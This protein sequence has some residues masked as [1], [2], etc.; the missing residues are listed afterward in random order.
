MIAYDRSHSS[1]PDVP[2]VAT[3]EALHAAA[4]RALTRPWF[5][6]RERTKCPQELSVACFWEAFYYYE[7]LRLYQS[8]VGGAAKRRQQIPLRTQRF[9][10]PAQPLTTDKLFL[11]HMPQSPS[12]F[13][14]LL[15]L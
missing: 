14:C 12:P 1:S 6:T 4:G 11:F 15:R 8:S 5:V 9:L 3:S 2:A 7:H 13:K 10:I